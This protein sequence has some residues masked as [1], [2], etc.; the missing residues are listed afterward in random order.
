[1]GDSNRE[2]SVFSRDGD[3]WTAKVQGQWVH[4]TSRVTALAWSPGGQVGGWVGKAG[5]EGEK[6]M[7][8]SSDDSNQY[9]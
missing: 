5:A 8:E 1:M 3:G 9:P 6:D 4:H 7:E 2:V